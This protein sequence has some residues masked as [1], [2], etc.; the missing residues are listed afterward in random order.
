MKQALY[1][2]VLLGTVVLAGCSAN[3]ETRAQTKS[4]EVSKVLANEQTKESVPVPTNAVVET[5]SPLQLTQ[6]QKKEY[7]KQYEEIVNQA[8]D[9]K[10]GINLGVPSIEE[11]EPEDWAEPEEYE[12]R[13]QEHI[14]SFLASEREALSNLSSP[15]SEVVIGSNGEKKKTAYLYVSDKIFSVEVSGEFDTQFSEYRKGQVF[16]KVDQITSHIASSSNGVWKQ[17]F[18]EAKLMDN[19]RTYSL[20]IEGVYTLNRIAT[21]KAFTVEFSCDEYGNIR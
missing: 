4:D 2:G 12:Q 11:F 6:E 9:T 14:D 5:K 13:I 3:E 20:L 8:N 21:K 7:H 18:S 1:I 15:M 19:G 16:S 17:T 10:I